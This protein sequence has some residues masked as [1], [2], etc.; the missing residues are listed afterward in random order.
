MLLSFFENNRIQQ[1]GFVIIEFDHHEILPS[2][3]RMLRSDQAQ[4]S[5]S[6][7]LEGMRKI[8]IILQWLYVAIIKPGHCK[9]ICSGRRRAGHVQTE[10]AVLDG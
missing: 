8:A 10:T 9:A 3:S 2:S 1:P 6:V 4:E 5:I 7:F